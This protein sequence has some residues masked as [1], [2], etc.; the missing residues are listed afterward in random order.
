MSRP[1]YELAHCVVCGHTDARVVATHDDI[2]DE[3]EQLWAFRGRRLRADTP[4]ARLIDR[5]AFSQDPPFRVVECR[6][7]GLVYRNPAERPRAL[8]ATYT[9]ESPSADTLRA[10]HAAQ[11]RAFATSARR[12]RERTARGA[13]GLEVGSYAGAFL[14]A[15]RS[16][17]L[18]FQG[19]DINA[20]VNA[21][22]RSLGF[23]VHDGSLDAFHPATPF[24]AVVIL[25]TFD[26]LAEP[27]AALAAAR[28]LVR[29]GG[30]LTIRVPNGA[31]YAALRDAVRDGR[32]LR[33]AL[34]R[35]VL[36]QNNLLT[37]P[38]R[39][40]FTAGSLRRL[41]EACGFDVE[42]VYGDVLP[43]T[44]DEWTPW[45]ARLEESLTKGLLGVVSRGSLALA[46]WLELYAV[47][48]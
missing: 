7:C 35:Q 3:V 12:V 48:S 25:N 45:W 6:E 2:L 31:L 23:T 26:Q 38:Y 20:D 41:V 44:S 13:T 47:C 18:A 22:V 32:G 27:R 16:A 34:A 39:W 9:R 43:R 10:L 36:A 28:R 29:P 19:L 11:S 15:A 40:G 24:D 14:A 30:V 5:V 1:A 4:P 42:A 8:E 17:G 33:R 37:F 21:F 46:P